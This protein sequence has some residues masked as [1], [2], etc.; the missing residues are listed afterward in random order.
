MS[1]NPM[2]HMEYLQNVYGRKK[3]AP[4]ILVKRDGI[5]QKDTLRGAWR[6]DQCLIIIGR[7]QPLTGIRV[8][9]GNGKVGYTR[10]RQSSVCQ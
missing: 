8:T 1:P 2:F 5:V 4:W 10:H 3:R 7:H 9:F 6:L